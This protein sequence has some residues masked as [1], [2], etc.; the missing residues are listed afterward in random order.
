MYSAPQ[1]R[2]SAQNSRLAPSASQAFLV[3]AGRLPRALVEHDLIEFVVVPRPSFPPELI[4]PHL[5]NSFLPLRI[6]TWNSSSLLGSRHTEPSRWRR[7]RA[8][9]EGLCDQQDIIFI[10][11][12][13]GTAADLHHLPTTHKWTGTFLPHLD[14]APTTRAG[15]TIVGIRTAYAARLASHT[16]RT[17]IQ[18]R[19][20]SARLQAQD[21]ARLQ[22]IAVHIDPSFTRPRIE[23]VMQKL[24]NEIDDLAPHF[25]IIGG[26]WNFME[27]SEGRLHTGA[28]HRHN[29][30]MVS[31]AF[32]RALP[33]VAEHFQPLHTFRRTTGRPEDAT[34]SRIDHWY[35][36]LDELA[37]RRT[38][39][40]VGVQ[41]GFHLPTQSSDHLPVT[42]TIRPRSPHHRPQARIS[43][44][45]ASPEVFGGI[46]ARKV[47]D[48]HLTGS[49]ARRLT[50][51]TELAHEAAHVTARILVAT[52][53]AAPKLYADA[54]IRAYALLRAGRPDD[55]SR[56]GAAIPRLALLITNIDYDGI[57]KYH[58]AQMEEQLLLD[59][60]TL[61]RSAA[62]EKHK[63]P[64]RA[65][66][67]KQHAAV[68]AQ[69]RRVDAS[70]PLQARRKLVPHRRRSRRGDEP[71]VGPGFLRPPPR[72][73]GHAVVHRI[74]P[75]SRARHLLALGT[76]FATRCCCRSSRL[77]P[78]HRRP[79]V[80]LLGICP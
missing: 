37:L 70:A 26:D 42:I 7:K 77:H 53:S 47:S 30:S 46:F 52:G 62:L 43:S 80:Q 19:S 17:V 33:H 66:L 20:V 41:G 31:P 61:E 18:G 69:Q 1:T 36:T 64:R 72:R 40:A 29:L 75:T 6:V 25:T 59:M 35:S 34:Y 73:R 23:Q 3:V 67:T 76:R 71:E 4:S 14:D 68:R 48:L 9:V 60:A 65:Q 32:H 58:R 55:A 12:A 49:P 2:P 16:S 28:G 63:T 44:Q 15:G 13:R 54:A 11:E 79:W 5:M 10:L 27:Q 39:I 50:S 45:V 8:Q 22:C 74:C 38:S 78:G 56:I 51:L 57:L 21:G 24:R